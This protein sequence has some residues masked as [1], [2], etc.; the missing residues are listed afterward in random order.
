MVLLFIALFNSILGLSVLFPI[1]A[2]LGQSLGLGEL[3]ITSLTTAYALMQLA[4]SSF[5]GR[6]SDR[7][8]RKPVLLTGIVGFAVS[9]FAFA[10]IAQLGMNGALGHGPLLG[11]LMISRV[12]GGIFSSATIPTAQA[13]AADLSAR[14]DRTS[15]MAVIGAAF[16]L[17]VVFGPAIGAGL[18]SL[19]GNLLAPVYFS[20][21]IA[22]LNAI[23]V[24]ARLP[25]PERY[26]T[27][28]PP[29]ALRSVAK[30]VWPLLAVGLAA[31]LS[32]VAMEQTVAFYF[33]FRLSLTGLETARTVGLALMGYGVV[34][35]VAQG[36]IV[37]RFK[38]SPITLLRV[39]VPIALCGFVLFLWARTY[40]TLTAALLVQGLG[41][42]L[43][44]PGV[45]AAVS[46]G[47]SE[48]E[49]GAVAGLNGASQGL[50]RT[51]GPIVG[52]GLYELKEY[53]P[54]AFSAGLLALVLLVIL[55]HP[56]I[57]PAHGGRLT[58]PLAD[59]PTE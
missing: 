58:T 17:G 23:F 37:R 52:G 32:S 54:Y 21:S 1:L 8:G 34:A 16:G 45:T 19:T 44:L 51:L 24:A 42:G 30:L 5:W 14:E 55:V 48:D 35:V 38:L 40:P 2:P 31:T 26:L 50:A 7:R 41:H 3:E 59:P 25:E 20:A 39:G 28:S 29:R 12:I 6:T 18:S 43:V 46:L 15:A 57:A 36:F 22:V 33:R 9:F 49:Q 47:V 27:D 4:M 53:L 13:Y 10:A 56:G 11:L